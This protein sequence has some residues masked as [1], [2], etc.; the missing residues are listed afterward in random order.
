MQLGRK[1][2]TG[3]TL[4]EPASRGKGR[5]RRGGVR[6]RRE[7]TTIAT[8]MIT[9]EALEEA[10]TLVS[11]LTQGGSDDRQL[12]CVEARVRRL[13]IVDGVQMIFVQ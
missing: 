7:T 2:G 4:S 11:K 5:E 12:G 10:M 1:S 13:E 8:T 6:E 9:G 3:T